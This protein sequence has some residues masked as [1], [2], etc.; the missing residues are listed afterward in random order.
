MTARKLRIGVLISGRGSN[1]QA[2]I[3]ACAAPDYPAEIVLVISNKADAFGLERAETAGIAH[4]TIDHK[5]F[6]DRLTFDR[7]LTEALEAAEV[8]L[9]AQAGF[10]RIL[11]GEFVAHWE[12]RMINIHPALLPL[13]PGL[14]THGRALAAGVKLHGCTVHYVSEE[15][16]AGPIIGQAAIPVLPDDSAD[17]LAA[18]VLEAEHRLY[19]HCLRLVAE[20]KVTIDGAV[21]HLAEGPEAAEALINPAP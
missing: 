2:L 16:D 3:D 20:G 1:L 12:G 15:V 10:M 17:S 6:P 21:T 7:A 5:A 8:E 11:T 18:R 14:N 19:P 4:Q 13:F 9:V